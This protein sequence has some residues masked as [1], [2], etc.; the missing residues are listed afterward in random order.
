MPVKITFLNL[1]DMSPTTYLW[2]VQFQG[3]PERGKID[4]FSRTQAPTIA[5]SNP[6][7]TEP[8]TMS[9]ALESCGGVFIFVAK[10]G[11]IPPPA[12]WAL[13]FGEGMGDH[14]YE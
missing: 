6:K 10:A 14:K 8:F 2:S 13:I 1:H 3:I 5:R 4:H 12:P 7:M 9:R 11:R